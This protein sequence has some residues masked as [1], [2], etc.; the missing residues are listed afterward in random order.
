[1]VGLIGMEIRWI[2]E[3]REKEW[4]AIDQVVTRRRRRTIGA[5]IQLHK[6]EIWELTCSIIKCGG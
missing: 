3:K 6:R 4:G 5:I 1:M 2:I